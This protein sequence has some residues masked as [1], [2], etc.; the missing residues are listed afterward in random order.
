MP[1]DDLGKDTVIHNAEIGDAMDAQVIVHA[2]TFR[3]WSHTNSTCRMVSK[4]NIAVL[5]ESGNQQNTA[6]YREVS[7][8]TGFQIVLGLNIQAVRP[9][10]SPSLGRTE[11][12]S[13]FG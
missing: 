8:R 10:S 6:K 7:G 4:A 2:S 12:L 13:L 5:V 3:K 1:T 9:S 11:G